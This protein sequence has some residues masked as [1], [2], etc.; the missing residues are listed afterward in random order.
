MSSG[1]TSSGAIAGGFTLMLVSGLLTLVDAPG[2]SYLGAI[3]IAGFVGWMS[4]D[5]D[6]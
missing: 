3:A 1:Q 5:R 2:W 4:D 6:Q